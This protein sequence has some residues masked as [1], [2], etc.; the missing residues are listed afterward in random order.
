[1]SANHGSLLHFWCAIAILL[2]SDAR[3]LWRHKR[4]P[5]EAREKYLSITTFFGDMILTLKSDNVKI[6]RC[7]HS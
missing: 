1:M 7:W 2:R 5:G 3:R 6:M 4:A